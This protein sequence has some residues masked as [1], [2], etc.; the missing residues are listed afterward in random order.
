MSA[1]QQLYTNSARRNNYGP[2]NVYFPQLILA[3]VEY[4]P[5]A[6]RRPVVAEDVIE[7]A[8]ATSRSISLDHSLSGGESTT[9][10]DTDSPLAT[11]VQSSPARPMKIIERVDEE[12]AWTVIGRRGRK[13][14]V[15][16]FS[17]DAEAAGP[18][19]LPS[20]QSTAAPSS[21]EDASPGE[22]VSGDASSPEDGSLMEDWQPVLARKRNRRLGGC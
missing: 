19:V 7:E 12:G 3:N 18:G 17:A 11:S 13:N 16:D 22:T 9:A 4:V 5:I 21:G 2:I 8:K 10:E 6:E 1:Q 14:L 20:P 15:F